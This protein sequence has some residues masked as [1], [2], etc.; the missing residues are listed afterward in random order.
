MEDEVGPPL[1]SIDIEW[2]ELLGSGE[3]VVFGLLEEVWAEEEGGGA[4][5]HMLRDALIF[6]RDGLLD[7]EGELLGSLPVVPP[8]LFSIAGKTPMCSRP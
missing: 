6:I 8:G 5:P 3:E 7:A 4:T 2:M 1:S